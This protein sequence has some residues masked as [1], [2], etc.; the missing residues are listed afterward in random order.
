MAA[1]ENSGN[2][3]SISKTG[4]IGCA[5]LIV[6]I[7]VIAGICAVIP[8]GG[9]SD[10]DSDPIESRWERW[11]DPW[12]GNHRNFEQLVKEKTS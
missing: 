7:A 8:G 3:P 4:C 9:D 2:R 11:F 6:L 5:G 12:D 10:S 1:T